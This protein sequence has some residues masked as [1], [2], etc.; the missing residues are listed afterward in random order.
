MVE[1]FG[2]GFLLHADRMRTFLLLAALA[3]TAACGAPK[4]VVDAGPD[5]S[6]G[7]DCVTQAHYGLIFNRCFEYSNDRFS[8]QTPP[9]LGVWV[10]PS[11]FELEGGKKSIEVQYR[12][13]G[14][15]V[16]TDFF[17][18][19]NGDLVLLRRIAQNQSVTYK[20]GADITGVK[21]LTV[22]TAA[23]EN[24]ST[25]STAFLSRD[26]S[27]TPVSYRMSTQAPSAAEQRTPLKTFDSAFTMVFGE[28]PSFGADSRRV[29]M[30]GIGFTLI[31]S[32][33]NLVGGSPTPV[34]LQRIR[35]I[36]TADAGTDSCSLGAP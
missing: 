31:A 1:V 36:G 7:L 16:Q 2:G 27:S 23:A 11:L 19:R 33:F 24:F 28:T 32:P 14:Q 29:F 17:D 8:G 35:D 30:P 34:Y 13:S 20:T 10:Q 15:I 22:S 26:N 12:Q 9:A 25:E 5:T 18:L 6:C 3:L 21:W 4:P